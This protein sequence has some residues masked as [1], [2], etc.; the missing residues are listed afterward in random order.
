[1]NHAEQG[2][3]RRFRTG[4][5]HGALR[6]GLILTES[7]L[8]SN[9][10][11]M[12]SIHGSDLSSCQYTRIRAWHP[13]GVASWP[14]PQNYPFVL[15]DPEVKPGRPSTIGMGEKVPVIA[16]SKVESG[17]PQ[18][19]AMP[20]GCVKFRGLNVCIERENGV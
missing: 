5:V 18:C 20:A 9:L 16:L 15:G 11:R 7:T 1:L 17:L 6:S 12:T 4:A 2:A 19:T 14:A 13:S 10:R 8:Q 3:H